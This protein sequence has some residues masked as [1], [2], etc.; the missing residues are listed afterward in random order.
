LPT[1]PMLKPTGK[2]GRK[3]LKGAFETRSRY[4]DELDVD[5][6][7]GLAM[8]KNNFDFFQDHSLQYLE[9][10]LRSDR[11]A[12]IKNPD[13]YGKRTGDSGDTVEFYLQVRQETIQ[14]L[15]FLTNGCINTTACCNAVAHLVEGRSV[16]EAWDIT[17]EDV[18][19]CRRIMCTVRSCL[20]G[21]FIWH[22]PI[23]SNSTLLPGKKC[24][25][26]N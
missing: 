21:P 19:P 3:I 22:C 6:Q 16:E 8:T 1:A 18:I 5:L 14:Y 12:L 2:A 23:I 24:I 11:R 10:A 9:M 17:P 15:S 26:D 7:C 20:S 4:H 13:G 25:E